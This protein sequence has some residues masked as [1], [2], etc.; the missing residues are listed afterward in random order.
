M[1]QGLFI[2]ELSHKVNV[3][4]PTIRYYERFGLLETPGRTASRY[5]IY[6]KEAEERLQF[7]QQAKRFGLSLEEIKQI[8]DLSTSGVAPCSRV[9]KMLKQHL[10]DVDRRIQEMLEFRQALTRQYMQLDD[11]LSDSSTALNPAVH[12]GKICGFIEKTEIEFKP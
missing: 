8:I 2:S 4:V 5:R 9:K 1:K 10:D 12:D 11:L 3:P 6:S 7:I